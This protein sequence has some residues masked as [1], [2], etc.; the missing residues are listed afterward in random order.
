MF[1]NLAKFDVVRIGKEA[2]SFYLAYLFLAL[3]MSAAAGA[4]GGLIDPKNAT[5]TAFKLGNIFSVI[6]CCAHFVAQKTAP[7]RSPLNLTLGRH[8]NMRE[9]NHEQSIRQ[10]WT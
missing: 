3:I 9:E 5:K 6:M 7:F 4:V 10:H 2:L 8:S 1:S